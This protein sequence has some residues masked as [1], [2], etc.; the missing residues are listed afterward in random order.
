MTMTEVLQL[1]S[2]EYVINTRQLPALPR[3]AVALTVTGDCMEGAQIFDGDTIILDLDRYPRANDP[4]AC[5]VHGQ[6]FVKEFIRTFAKGV[7]LVGTHYTHSKL[8][9]ANADGSIL[10]N[11]G[12]LASELGGVVIGCFD[13]SGSLRW[14]KDYH[15]FPEEPPAPYK[16]PKDEV[17]FVSVLH[18]S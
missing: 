1:P 7:Y 9:K 18:N 12:L 5:F 15:D 6:F 16:H 14:A 17:E 13:S 2:R 4:C 3:R 11:Y 8:M 10:M